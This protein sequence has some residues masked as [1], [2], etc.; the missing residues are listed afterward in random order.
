MARVVHTLALSRDKDLVAYLEIHRL[1]VLIYLYPLL[2]LH[3]LNSILGHLPRSVH[4]L[5]ELD[6]FFVGELLI[7]TNEFVP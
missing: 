4:P 7:D 3:L 1:V 5:S 2:L 6:C